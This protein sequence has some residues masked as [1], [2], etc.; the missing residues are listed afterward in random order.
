M[1]RP[2][3]P[4]QLYEEMKTSFLAKLDQ[5]LSRSVAPKDFTERD[6]RAVLQGGID[7][8]AKLLRLAS[9]QRA[10]PRILTI[11]VWLLPRWPGGARRPAFLHAAQT[12]LSHPSPVVRAEAAVSMGLF[13]LRRAPSV[14]LRALDDSDD[15]VRLRI[16]TSLGLHGD[17]KTLPALVE[18]LSDRTESAAVRATAA[19]AMS[20][21][22][23]LPGESALLTALSDPSPKV[24]ASAAHSLGQLRVQSAAQILRKL[25]KR[26]PRLI[27]RDAARSALEQIVPR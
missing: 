27:V 10:A 19:D 23:G 18:V 16:I 15:E 8:E 3:L 21:F 22:G 2:P 5:A 14:L 1:L 20:G 25:V 4:M 17:E 7:S 9:S 12:L 13:R 11:V 24:R 6:R 26:D